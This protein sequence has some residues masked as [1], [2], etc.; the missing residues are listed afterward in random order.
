LLLKSIKLGAQVA[1]R[2]LCAGKL[3]SQSL[4]L[5]GLL[6]LGYEQLFD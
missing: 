1:I 4:L 6:L 5:C 3:G 2:F